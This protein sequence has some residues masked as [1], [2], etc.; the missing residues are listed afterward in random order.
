M[1]SAKVVLTFLLTFMFTLVYGSDLP[2]TAASLRAR[3]VLLGKG[4]I[5][6]YKWAVVVGRDYGRSGGQR[7]C[8]VT[9]SFDTEI[10]KNPAD[11]VTERSLRVCSP[12]PPRGVPNIV[13]L[14]VGKGD[15]EMTI[16]GM[17]FSP[18]IAAVVLDLGAGGEKTVTL[19][20]LKSAQMRQAGV[21]SIRYAAFAMRGMLCLRQVTGYDQAGMEISQFPLG[22]GEPCPSLP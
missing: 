7:P 2:I 8:V 5:K 22:E 6:G 19:R 10:E 20:A 18:R 13:S 12:L 11:F 3:P 15:R 16:V 9:H 1:R 14:S 21:R 17:A 4:Q